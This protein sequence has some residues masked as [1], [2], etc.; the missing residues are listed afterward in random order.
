[1]V[2]GDRL[3]LTAERVGEKPL[4][5]WTSSAWQIAFNST[6]AATT[7]LGRVTRDGEAGLVTL[8]LLVHAPGFG[9]FRVQATGSAA[10]WRA[11]SIRPLTTVTS[12]LKLGEV[13]QTQG[14]YVLLPGRHR[15]QVEFIV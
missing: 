5:V 13:A 9:T 2:G 1:E 15:A 3:R 6:V 4:R 7:N 11:D 12:E 14:D 10:S 8:P